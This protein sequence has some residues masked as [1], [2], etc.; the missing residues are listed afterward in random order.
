MNGK[1]KNMLCASVMAMALTLGG[2]I[3]AP[4]G[5]SKPDYVMIEFGAVAAFTVIVN[6]TKVS[7]EA[8]VRAY[9]GLTHLEGV[10]QTGGPLNLDMVDTLLARAVPIE[11]KA[12]AATGSKLIR[13]RV[14]QYME[15]KLPTN[16]ITE[17]EVIVNSTLAVVQGAKAALQPKY[18]MITK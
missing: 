2:C 1:L 5:S 17:N 16:P 3:S 7:D 13:S 12:L 14:A 4:D 11:Y 15:V 9:E 6:E 18:D 8:I 10:L